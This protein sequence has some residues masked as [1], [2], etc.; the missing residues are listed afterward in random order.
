MK[1]WKRIEPT[2]VTKVGYR[3]IVTKTFVRPDGTVDTYDIKDAEHGRCVSTIALTPDNQVIIARQFRPG[4]ERV[5]EEIPGGVV[6]PHETDLEAAARREL[7]EETG[8]QAA[9]MTYLGYEYRDS[10]TNTVWHYFL[11][12]GC[13]V[14]EHSPGPDEGEYITIEYIPI[15]TLIANARSG[16]MTDTSA[17]FMAYDILQTKL[18][19]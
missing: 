12:T 19:S 18:R 17:V 13:T 9:D 8:Y 15:D 14:S 4:P 2:T 5:M 11:A 10:Y 6:E 16:R 3:T 7:L 1:P